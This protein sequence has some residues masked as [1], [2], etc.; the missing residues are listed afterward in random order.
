[1]STRLLFP[2]LGLLFTVLGWP[3]ANRRV[4][5]NR[6]YGLRVP[7]TFADRRVWYDAN[8]L[9]GRDMMGL[10][11]VVLL[12]A[13]LLPVLIRLPEGVYTGVCAAV[14]GLGSLV[15]SVRG[16]R[17]ANRMLRELRESAAGPPTTDH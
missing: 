4:Q 10:G 2:T 8:E 7:A 11:V 1:M 15:L 13:L 17:A 3:L 12:V 5:P 14:L 16:W 6:W 9:T